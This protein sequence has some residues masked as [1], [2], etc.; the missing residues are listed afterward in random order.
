[1]TCTNGTK[2]RVVPLGELTRIR[3]T[4]IVIK[5]LEGIE[6][7]NELHNVVEHFE[8]NPANQKNYD[9]VLKEHRCFQSIRLRRIIVAKESVLCSI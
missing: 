2:W 1:M 7:M 6:L 9:L 3:D 8:H 5:F 4:V